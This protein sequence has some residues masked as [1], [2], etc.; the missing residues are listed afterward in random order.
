MNATPASAT[1]VVAIARAR[2][3]DL[4]HLADALPEFA[5]SPAF[6]GGDDGYGGTV[7]DVLAHIHEQHGVLLHALETKSPP[8]AVTG[9]LG[10]SSAV[11]QLAHRPYAQLRALLEDSHQALCAA[12]MARDDHL[13]FDPQGYPWLEGRSLGQTAHAYLGQRYEWAQTV[14]GQ[15]AL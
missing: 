8:R 4:L 9:H 1:A 14:L 13:L 2:L 3:A 5:V 10:E 15:C 7:T 11:P 6:G 12:L